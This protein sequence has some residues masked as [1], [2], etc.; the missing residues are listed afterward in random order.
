[1][2]PLE[3]SAGLPGNTGNEVAKVKPNETDPNVT[4]GT[5]M[6]MVVKLGMGI[7]RFEGSNENAGA[8]TALDV[9][10]TATEVS[11]KL[12]GVSPAE[13]LDGAL[14]GGP[15][16]PTA[17]EGCTSIL[18]EGVEAVVAAAGDDS[19][20]FTETDGATDPV[21]DES[22]EAGLGMTS[23]LSALMM[24]AAF[25]AT[26]YTFAWRCAAGI[27]GKMPASTTRRFCVP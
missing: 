20:E 25:S 7:T 19:P 15:D 5:V 13:E 23:R 26:A 14:L 8:G 24:S 17:V 1:M 11:G 4:G 16:C 2:P 12:D 27:R 3:L 10:D 21:G 18:A 9:D 22:D 6:V